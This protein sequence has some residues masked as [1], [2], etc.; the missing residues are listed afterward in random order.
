MFILIDFS[1]SIMETMKYIL[2]NKV[3]AW[4]EF[5]F[6]FI[7]FFY[8]L[9][10]KVKNDV[11][12]VKNLT[13]QLNFKLYAILQKSVSCEK[14]S[15]FFLLLIGYHWDCYLCKFTHLPC[16]IWTVK[17][18]HKTTKSAWHALRCEDRMI[19][20]LRRYK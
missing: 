12:S 18:F 9:L 4:T 11:D 14:F 2:W 13:F 8:F 19:N 3:I 10:Y 16:K 6:L 15:F 5:D 7:L 20:D 1:V 17:V